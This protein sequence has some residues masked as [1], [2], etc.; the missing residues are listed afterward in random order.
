[1]RLLYVCTDFGV[2]PSGTKGASVHLRAITRAL[3]EL[4]HEVFLL[5]PLDGPNEE[6]PARRLLES[7][8][9]AIKDSIG[10]LKR[11]L[12]E[13]DLEDTLARELRP[14][15]YNAWVQN[16]ALD[17]ASRIRP[18]VIVER[19]SLLGHVGSDLAEA[20]RVP[21]ILEVNALLTEESRDFRNLQ[22]RD[23]AA[24]IEQRVLQRADAV[25]AVSGPLAARIAAQGIAPG[26]V[27][28]VC[29]GVDLAEFENLPSRSAG[30]A[31]LGLEG[32]FVVGFCG[33]LKVW[34]GV[35]MLLAAFAEFSKDDPSARLLI[36]GSGPEEQSLRRAAESLGLAGVVIFT[37]AVSHEAV[38]GLLAVMDV[39]VAPFRAMEQFYFSPIKLFEYMAAGTCV[40]ASR[41]GQMQEVIQDGVNGLLFE[42]DDVSALVEVLRKARRTPEFRRSLAARAEETVRQRFT[43]SHAARHT[44]K[45]I[46]QALDRR[47][48]TAGS[49]TADRGSL[50]EAVETAG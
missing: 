30:R 34:H 5:S 20:L 37:G 15:V 23:L 33:S 19:L 38:A 14:L 46:E 48:Q 49:V 31:A 12:L 18:D 42:A 29:N 4:G 36:V 9:P 24:T 50:A 13:H 35:D 45:I 17:A 25:C 43:W 26:K 44:L 6:H 3:A 40:I 7:G 10:P 8:C 1:M 39:A 2:P 16:R 47:S 22:F 21:L 41:L 32:E 28:V 27:H 11:W